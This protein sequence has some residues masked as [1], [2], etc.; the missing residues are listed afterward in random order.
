MT[1][2]ILVI[3]QLGASP[4]MVGLLYAALPFIQFLSKPIAG[5]ISD[6]Y[7]IPKTVLIVSIIFFAVS[8][9]SVNFIPKPQ[10][11]V[12]SND[13]TSWML[14]DVRVSLNEDH[15]NFKTI[16]LCHPNGAHI[17]AGLPSLTCSLSCQFRDTDMDLR[18]CSIYR[19]DISMAIKSLDSTMD[20][21]I[22]GDCYIFQ[23]ESMDQEYLWN[24]CAKNLSMSCQTHCNATDSDDHFSSMEHNIPFYQLVWV[25]VACSIA[26]ITKGSAYTAG[27]VALV[28][29]LG[30]DKSAYGRTRFFGSLGWGLMSVIAAQLIDWQSAG[31]PRKD[32]SPGYYVFIVFILLDLLVASQIQISVSEKPKS[33]GK[34]VLH[35]FKDAE[36]CLFS[37]GV[38]ITGVISAVFF[39][40]LVVYANELSGTQLIIGLNYFVECFLSE[41]PLFLVAGWLISKLGHSF[42]LTFIILVSGFKTLCYSFIDDAWYILIIALMHGCNF[43]TLCVVMASYSTVVAPPGGSVTVQG[44]FHGLFEGIGNYIFYNFHT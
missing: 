10:Y 38:F 34:D 15:Q 6:K 29:I 32:Y 36:F 1:P 12:A 9:F 16:T 37:F 13:S 28:T 30:D 33:L 35:L 27:E 24:D 4:S 39:T 20:E 8:L 41:I 31:L 25:W 18:N 22:M 2:L 17:W 7:Q 26:W 5:G 14:D 43:A 3:I 44:I 21:D 11:T 40:F 42:C 23:T 19:R